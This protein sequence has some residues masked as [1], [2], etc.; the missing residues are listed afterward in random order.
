MSEGDVAQMHRNAIP[1]VTENADPRDGKSGP[2]L[3]A[4]AMSAIVV[5]ATLALVVVN[6]APSADPQVIVGR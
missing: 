1:G 2:W 5:G 3:A 6:I 4:F